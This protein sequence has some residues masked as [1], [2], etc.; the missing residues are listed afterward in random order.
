MVLGVSD[1]ERQGT[2]PFSTGKG[3]P[4]LANA[5][6]Q[7]G[8][9]LKQA[10]LSQGEESACLQLVLGGPAPLLAD[11]LRVMSHSRPAAYFNVKKKTRCTLK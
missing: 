5:V 11:P 9:H 8:V 10:G 2:F 6:L 1:T 4:R 7:I 3:N